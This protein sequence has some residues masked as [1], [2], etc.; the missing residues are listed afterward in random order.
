MKVAICGAGIVGS[1]LAYD[2]A[3]AG[4]EILVID[5]NPDIEKRYQDRPPNIAWLT[6]DACEVASLQNAHLE[7]K[8]VVVATTGDDEDNLVIS[9]LS[10]Q[11]FAVPRVVARV[12]HPENLWLFNESWGVDVAISTPHLL[13]AVVEEAVNVGTLVRVLQFEGGNA[14]LVEVT[15]AESSPAVGKTLAELNFP[16]NSTVVAVIRQDHLIMPRGDTVLDAMDEVLA[17]VTQESE[18]DV[19]DILIGPET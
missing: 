6:A 16:R 10:K 4:H 1:F 14:R 15:L 19:R 5:K 13:S 9:L 2:L 8:D 12:N 3:K 11:E 17:L 18:A 7:D